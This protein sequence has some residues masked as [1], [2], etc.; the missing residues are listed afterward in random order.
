LESSTVP[1]QKGEINPE[2]YSK[3]LPLNRDEKSGRFVASVNSNG[4]IPYG[5]YPHYEEELKNQ[6]GL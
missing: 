4:C 2:N 6:S 5:I 1:V 3:I